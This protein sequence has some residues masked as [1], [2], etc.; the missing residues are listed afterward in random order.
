[1]P[2]KFLMIIIVIYRSGFIWVLQYWK[3]M[4]LALPLEH[5]KKAALSKKL[6]G[7][8]KILI[9]AFK[10]VGKTKVGDGEEAFS[11]WEEI[12]LFVYP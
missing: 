9:C 2:I 1:M 7:L 12:F 3:G 10:G 8:D 6:T 4:V 11:V 5:C